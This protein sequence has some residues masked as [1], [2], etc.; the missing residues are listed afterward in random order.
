MKKSDLKNYAFLLTIFLIGKMEPA[1]SILFDKESKERSEA[2][3][4]N[5][6]KKK[7]KQKKAEE[8]K[9]SGKDKAIKLEQVDD[10]KSEEKKSTKSNKI[11]S[12]SEYEKNFNTFG[13]GLDDKGSKTKE[14]SKT[15]QENIQ[16]SKDKKAKGIEKKTAEKK[17]QEKKKEEENSFW[18]KFKTGL[19]KAGKLAQAVGKTE[20]GETFKDLGKTV[21]KNSVELGLEKTVN[22][23]NKFAGAPIARKNEKNVNEEEVKAVDIEEKTTVEDSYSGTNT[24]LMTDEEYENN[25][26]SFGFGLDEKDIKT[27]IRS[28]EKEKNREKKKARKNKSKSSKEETSLTEKKSEV[29]DNDISKEEVIVEAKKVVE[30]PEEKEV[31]AVKEVK[32]EEPKKETVVVSSVV[33]SSASTSAPRS[34]DRGRKSARQGRATRTAKKRRKASL[35]R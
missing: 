10:K 22:G 17:E 24:T 1:K 19:K 30:K 21:V 28:E 18:G 13:F 32:A 12:D 2:K 27:K 5:R 15:K 8:K 11:M 26:N 35:R 25:F 7:E 16:K 33:E 34:F 3:Q 9:N 14:K 20:I 31:L 6:D 29:K 4:V 23:I